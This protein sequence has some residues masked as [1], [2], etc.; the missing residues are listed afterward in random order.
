MAEN[1]GLLSSGWSMVGRNKRY[2]VW[3]YVFNVML[4]WFGTVAFSNQA[5]EMLDHSLL[6]DR[7]VHGFDLGVWGEMFAQPQFPSMKTLS[8]PATDFAFLFFIATAL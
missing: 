8:A 4:A 2:I 3:F 1:Q 7:M 6:S 5:H